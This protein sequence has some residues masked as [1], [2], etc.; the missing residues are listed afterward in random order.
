MPKSTIARDAAW[1]GVS[2]AYTPSMKRMLFFALLLSPSLLAQTVY[3]TVE[4][5]VTTYSDSPPD[6]GTAEVLIIDVAPI[7]EDALLEERLAAM[8][9]TTD[10]MAADRRE[11]EK[12]RAELREIQQTA[13][14]PALDTEPASSTITTNWE[15][16]YL[17]RYVRP[18][19]PRPPIRPGL[20]G[21]PQPLPQ[22]ESVPGWSVLEPGNSQL[23]RPVVSSRR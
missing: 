16:D 12:R 2:L 4:G 9:D 17:P 20:P 21:R 10:R 6:T 8:R 1:I 22:I 11:R 14:A 19:R 7:A 5:G 23:M 18:I 15:S 3:K 13:A